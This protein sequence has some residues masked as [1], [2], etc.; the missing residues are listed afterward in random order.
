MK[1]FFSVVVL[2]FV[3]QQTWCQFDD[4]SDT[5]SFAKVKKNDAIVINLLNNQI[6]NV[7]S[8][9]TQMPVS[10][11]LEIYT[12]E[13]LFKTNRTFNFSLGLGISSHNVHNNALPYD[14]LGKTYFKLIPPGYKYTKNKITVNYLEILLEINI[15]SRVDKRGRNFRLAIGG[16]GGLMLSNYIK[17]V[18]EDFR[19]LSKKEVKFKEYRLENISWYRYGLYFRMSY[20]RFGVAASYMLSPLFEKDKGPDFIPF[21]YGFTFGIK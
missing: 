10:L 2:F 20:G 7:K 3:F 18:G 4:I 13:P 11:G 19:N 9:M 15:V 21:T 12:F 16:K 8:P 5:T 6:L 1:H 14:S 17:Y